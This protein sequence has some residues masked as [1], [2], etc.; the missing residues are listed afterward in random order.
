MRR[1]LRR[2]GLLRLR[3]VTVTARRMGGAQ[4]Y[5]SPRRAHDRWVSLSLSPSYALVAADCGGEMAAHLTVL[6]E[7]SS[8][9]PR[10]TGDVGALIQFSRQF[11]RLFR[12]AR[13]T[14]SIDAINWR[15]DKVG[16]T[17]DPNYP[18]SMITCRWSSRSIC[19]CRRQSMMMDMTTM[20][21]GMMLTM[22]IY[23]LAI[24]IF[25]VLGI[26]AS[27]KYLRS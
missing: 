19:R 21:S 8:I 25:A 18:L 16:A 7:R 20:G 1:R 4:R 13:L 24:F 5:P 23:H 11:H 22:G 6:C 26:A 2:V 17:L 10:N 14:L 27:I 9:S 12:R 3:H 15:L